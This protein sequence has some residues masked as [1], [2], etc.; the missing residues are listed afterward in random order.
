MFKKESIDLPD[1]MCVIQ[2]RFFSKNGLN[3]L[4]KSILSSVTSAI[5]EPVPKFIIKL[6]FS[7][8]KAD[9]AFWK[10]PIP[11]NILIL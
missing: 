1:G 6:L 8:F 2:S 11:V 9:K 5:W 10:S 7:K 3:S 4:E